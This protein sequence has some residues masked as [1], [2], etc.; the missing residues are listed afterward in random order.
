MYALISAPSYFSCEPIRAVCAVLSWAFA[1]GS[2]VRFRP[3]DSVSSMDG[4]GRRSALA[5]D[6]SPGGDAAASPQG[7]TRAVAVITGAS[8]GIGLALAREF[9]R[10][11]H[12]LFLVARGIDQLERVALEIERDFGV[13]VYA[14]GLDLLDSA[15]SAGLADLLA[16]RRLHADVLIN[17]AGLSLLSPLDK[18]PLDEALRVVDLNVRAATALTMAFLPG[19]VKRG[20][21]AVLNVASLAGLVPVPNMAVYGASKSYLIALSRALDAELRGTGVHVSVLAPGPVRTGMLS[22]MGL[23]S[24]ERLGWRVL[25]LRPEMVARVAYDGLFARRG[26]ITPGL[27]GWLAAVGIGSLPGAAVLRLAGWA[28]RARRAG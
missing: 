17:N 16:A 24:G 2:C 13:K 19:M 1:S 15:A 12:A 14:A 8:R 20:H 6:A 27:F 5:A 26:M 4:S 7:M 21:G 18:T 9:A 11:G 3:H 22:G 25:A 28:V 10:Q 23:D